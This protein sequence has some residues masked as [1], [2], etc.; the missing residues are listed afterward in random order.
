MSG[1]ESLKGS[2]RESVNMMNL[3][4]MGVKVD[5]TSGHMQLESLSKNHLKIPI[6]KTGADVGY[7]NINRSDPSNYAAASQEIKTHGRPSYPK[8]KIQN[9][10]RHDYLRKSMVDRIERKNLM[11]KYQREL[12]RNNR[13]RSSRLTKAAHLRSQSVLEH[14]SGSVMPGSL[15]TLEMSSPV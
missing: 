5:D 7:D 3:R 1:T 2:D 11:E 8:D 10:I 13:D 4:Q 12:A 9:V 14:M 15:K 6:R